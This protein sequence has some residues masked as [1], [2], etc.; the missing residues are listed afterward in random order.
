MNKIECFWKSIETKKKKK[1]QIDY[2]LLN[3]SPEFILKFIRLGGGPRLGVLCEEFARFSFKNLLKRNK[4]KTETGYDH[5][6]KIEDKELF[7][8]QKSSGLWN[9]TDYK[10]QHIEIKHKWDILLLCGIGFQNIN[11][12]LLTREIFDK[13]LRENKIT[14]Q[15]NKEGNSLEGFWMNYSD[16]KENLIQVDNS[17]DFLV[18]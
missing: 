15:G 1:R 3:N 14:P 16:I 12:W 5:I 18:I 9:G 10:W 7:V 6:L 2:Y 8:E 11:F 4:G 13:L 17:K